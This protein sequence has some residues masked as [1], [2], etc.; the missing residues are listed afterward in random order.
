ME[1]DLHSNRR[2][3]EAMQLDEVSGLANGSAYQ[4][5]R[6]FVLIASM[7]IMGLLLVLSIG[8]WYR[9]VINQ[10]ASASGQSATRAYYYAESAINYLGLAMDDDAE[11]DGELPA[12]D[13]IG[14]ANLYGDW[15][16]VSQL[17]TFLPGPTT[18]GGTDGQLA[19]F[20]NRP[21]ANR[22]G[23]AFVNANPSALNPDFSTLISSG[24]MPQHLVLNIDT[25]G[26]ITL[27]SPSYTT[28]NPSATFNGALLW[29][30]AVDSG[31]NDVQLDPDPG[32]CT[33][34]TNAVACINGAQV[35]TYDVGVY[36]LAFVN[37]VPMVLLRAAVKSIP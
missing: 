2:K 14:D 3:Y 12:N 29:L 28:A 37:G 1:T 8:L 22:N 18:L 35:D 11:L 5:E 33:S 25:N 13:P 36:A 10:Q 32:S 9:S 19:Y 23:F 7:V 6:G 21:I 4:S 26:N 31:N 15:T 27:A 30:T 17:N 24:Q 34:I 16:A 20:D